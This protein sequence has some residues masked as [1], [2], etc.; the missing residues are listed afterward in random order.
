MEQVQVSP[1]L[2]PFLCHT[3][4]AREPERQHTPATAA[5]AITDFFLS[6]SV[7]LKGPLPD[8][9][10]YGD[11]HARLQRHTRTGQPIPAIVQ[12][13]G[14]KTAGHCPYPEPD[15]VEFMALE[16]LVRIQTM[17]R[18]VYRPGLK[19]RFFIADSFYAYVFGYDESVR[20]Y[21]QGLMDLTSELDLPSRHNITP[22]AYSQLA[23]SFGE[24][25]IA[26]RCEDNCRILSQYWDDRTPESYQRLVDA[27]WQGSLPEE[28]RAHCQKRSSRILAKKGCP[29]PD[30]EREAKLAAIRFLAYSLMVRQF[31]LLDRE[32]EGGAI[33]ISYVPIAPGEPKTLYRRFRIAPSPPGGTTR[34]APPWTVQGIFRWPGMKPSI[35]TYEDVEAVKMECMKQAEFQMGRCTLRSD[36]YQTRQ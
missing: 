20:P 4:K 19:I 26:E 27:G 36:I 18:G 16:Q 3:V 31:D 29:E 6:R 10:E 11:M 5:E 35:Y 7:R 1:Y 9:N 12:F 24:Q 14:S 2:E 13:G 30:L 32:E 34:S 17:V 28:Q 23:R 15:L 33:D 25:K 8:N 22:I 21:R